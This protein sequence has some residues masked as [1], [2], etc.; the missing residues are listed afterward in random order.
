ML[1]PYLSVVVISIF[2]S[3]FA[4]TSVINK[5]FLLFLQFYWHLSSRSLLMIREVWT[6]RA[7]NSLVILRITVGYAV[8]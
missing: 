6:V 3:K 1:T 8:A 7:G 4:S 5:T 2:V